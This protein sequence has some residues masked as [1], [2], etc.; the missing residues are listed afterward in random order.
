MRML[1]GLRRCGNGRGN[2]GAS[3]VTRCCPARSRLWLTGTLTCLRTSWRTCG[4][5]RAAVSDTGVGCQLAVCSEGSMVLLELVL[6]RGLNVAFP[7]SP[8]A[9]RDF[10]NSLGAAI[11]RA[12]TAGVTY[13]RN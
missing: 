10:S 8:D 9:A 6:D 2:G 11:K 12:S 13:G 4:R 7:M 5:S 3:R 1:R